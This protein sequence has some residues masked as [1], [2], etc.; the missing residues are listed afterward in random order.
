MKQTLDDLIGEGYRVFMGRSAPQHNVI[1][2]DLILRL[3]EALEK[4]SK[5]G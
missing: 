5:G 1:L 2:Y 4:A 3:T